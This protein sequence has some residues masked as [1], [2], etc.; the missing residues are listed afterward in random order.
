LR[1][2]IDVRVF[3][4]YTL[5]AEVICRASQSTEATKL[6]ERGNVNVFFPPAFPRGI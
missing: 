6:N 2:E 4:A 3:S 5:S 1:G